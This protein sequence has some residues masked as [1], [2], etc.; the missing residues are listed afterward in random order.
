MTVSKEVSPVSK[1]EGHILLFT[2]FQGKDDVISD[3]KAH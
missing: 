1:A 2:G 3:E